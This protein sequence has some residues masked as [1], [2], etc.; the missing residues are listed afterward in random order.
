MKKYNKFILENIVGEVSINDMTKYLDRMSYGL[1]DKMFFVGK[2]NFDCIVDFG[3]A[4]GVLLD[5][6]KK[7]NP[8]ICTVAYEID[9]TMLDILKNKN[10][11]YVVDNFNNVNE[12]ISKYKS[13]MLLLS[14]VI[15]E[16]YSYSTKED[17]NNF[18]N[19]IFNNNFKYIVIRDM[20]YKDKFDNFNIN[21]NDINKV[22]KN[23][24]FTLSSYEKIWGSIRK[25]YHNLIH[26]LLKYRYIENWDRESKENYMP[27]KIEDIK[28]LISNNWIVKYEKEYTLDFLKDV[29]KKD[30]DIDIKE[31]TH[32]K[33]ILQN[34]KLNENNIDFEDWDDDI[35]YD[36]EYLVEG[37]DINDSVIGQIIMDKNRNLYVYAKKD[38]IWLYGYQLGKIVKDF[39]GQLYASLIFNQNQQKLIGI[40]KIVCKFP[41][42]KERNMILKS[43]NHPV[44]KPYVK[45][46]E[47]KI[48]NKIK[49]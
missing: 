3:A 32:I 47:N 1:W 25:N 19:I 39:T 37:D 23:A 18:W 48:N 12:I 6:I 10:I 29:I 31:P 22:Y 43:F 36:E 38:D 44:Y 17:V 40:R 28:K 33:L 26:Y 5:M 16:I 14:S 45:I 35:Y 42:D 7:M 11:D 15:H 49:V 27:I 30:F 8:D 9:S 2:I 41:N 34:S 4:D 21:D 20:I 13:P 46:I 24:D